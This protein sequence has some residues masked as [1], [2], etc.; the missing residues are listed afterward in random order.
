MIPTMQE[1]KE[2]FVITNDAAAM[3]AA[4]K[5]SEAERDKAALKM[6]YDA[7]YK[8]ACTE[9]DGTISYMQDLLRD[10]FDHLPDV[11]KR[12]TK[13]QSKYSLPGLDMVYKPR[14]KSYIPDK[15]A[16]LGFVKAN[17][18]LAQYIKVTESAD[19][20]GLKKISE[21]VEGDD[22]TVY[23]VLKETGE[24]LPVSVT[25]EDSFTVKVATEGTEE[26]EVST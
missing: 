13:T 14:N 4:R 16:L 17:D 19:W 6:H 7:Q 23:R 2:P 18:D 9:L 10:Y 11:V 21:D 12:T 5:I 3:W 22:G 20:A 1:A 8:K 25:V 26:N 24:V 15:D